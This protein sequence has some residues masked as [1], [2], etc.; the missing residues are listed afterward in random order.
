MQYND[1][2]QA[3]P[4]F[5]TADEI[6]PSSVSHIVTHETKNHR[7]YVSTP[8]PPQKDYS[9]IKD[10]LYRADYES[11]EAN[12]IVYLSSNR[13]QVKA[14]VVFRRFQI[15]DREARGETRRALVMMILS[16][17]FAALEYISYLQPMFEDIIRVLCD[18]SKAI[19]DSESQTVRQ[20]D[21][22]R[23]LRSLG[24]LLKFNDLHTFLHQK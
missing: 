16:D 11:A 18:K 24:T 12:N 8:S 9:T 7:T 21:G 22:L 1:Q 23:P 3:E 2:R 10:S 19:Y 15:K 13:H 6:F 5:C 17:R 20:A 14:S 4:E